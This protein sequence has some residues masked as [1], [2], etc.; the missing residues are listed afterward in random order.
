[1]SIT[2]L[3]TALDAIEGRITKTGADTRE[4]KKYLR[5]S[6]NDQRVS[7]SLRHGILAK[8][9]GFRLG[10]RHSLNFEAYDVPSLYDLLGLNNMSINPEVW[11]VKIP[12]RLLY[13]VLKSLVRRIEKTAACVKSEEEVQRSEFYQD[14]YTYPPWAQVECVGYTLSRIQRVWEVKDALWRDGVKRVNRGSENA[15]RIEN[16]CPKLEVYAKIVQNQDPISFHQALLKLSSLSSPSN[17]DVRTPFTSRRTSLNADID[18]SQLSLSR[19]THLDP[20]LAHSLTTPTLDLDLLN[21]DLNLRSVDFGLPS[22]RHLVQLSL[23]TSN[24]STLSIDP[25]RVKPHLHLVDLYH[26]RKEPETLR[27]EGTDG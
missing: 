16:A 21:V 2:R 25:L 18:Y 3:E 7:D 8:L 19:R 6:W 27:L 10:R 12:R 4:L 1:M 11:P 14:W 5:S 17:E 15:R 13:E 9:Q 20:I 24:K 23:L 26:C 22:E